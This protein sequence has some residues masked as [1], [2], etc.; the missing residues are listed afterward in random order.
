MR[1]LVK[2]TVTGS[3][4]LTAAS[5]LALAQSATAKP[6][7][8]T[9]FFVTST[10]SG[11]GGDLGGLAGAD[12]HCTAL[13]TAAGITGKTWHAY[14]STSGAGGV[15]ARDR[16][17]TGPWFNAKG[18]QIAASVDDLHSDNNKLN[19]EN[20]LSEK[21]TLVNGVGDQPN[22]HDVLTGSDAQGRL[23]APIA[24]VVANAPAGAAPPAPPANMSCNNWTSSGPG[25]VMLG[26][27]DRLGTSPLAVSWNASHPGAGCSQADLISTG[28]AGLFYC[29][30]IR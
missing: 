2:M 21:G 28:G 17:G 6:D 9:S 27:H 5:S 8:K 7:P 30:A 20:S 15:N 24:R 25:G 14:L 16:I 22:Q 4:L 13:A 12:A 18:V 3:L 1:N 26:H 10:G 11:K 29:F 23:Q 19:K